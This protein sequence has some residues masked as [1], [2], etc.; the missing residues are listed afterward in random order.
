MCKT[1]NERIADF[2][3]KSIEDKK[4]IG[5]IVIGTVSASLAQRIKES[6]GLKVKVGAEMFID[7]NHVR[8]ICNNKANINPKD[9]LLVADIV[10]HSQVIRKGSQQK[11]IRFEKQII[12]DYTCIE[13]VVSKGSRLQLKT[14]WV[15]RKGKK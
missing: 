12:Y 13:A 1:L 11:T 2:V 3:L 8:H 5:E 7:A 15:K 10:K 4:Y 6:V 9:F 14:L